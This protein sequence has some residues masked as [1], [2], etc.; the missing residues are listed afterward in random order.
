MS[1][2]QIFSALEKNGGSSVLLVSSD[3]GTPA[4]VASCHER[5]P[6]VPVIVVA[7]AAE[8]KSRQD[9]HAFAILDD[10][11]SAGDLV[12]T[13]VVAAEQGLPSPTPAAALEHSAPINRSAP[14]AFEMSSELAREMEASAAAD[15][16]E[17]DPIGAHTLAGAKALAN[18]YRLLDGDEFR[19]NGR[20]S[21]HVSLILRGAKQRPIWPATSAALVRSLGRVSL[22]MALL[23]K[24]DRALPLAPA[25]K[26]AVD[27]IASLTKSIVE[28]LP[29]SAAVMEVLEQVG[30]RFD[31]RVSAGTPSRSG[32]R[33]VAGA[34]A[35]RLAIDYDHAQA[36]G[37]SHQDVMKELGAD[38]GRYD[39]KM[40][41]AVEEI[42]TP[43]PE[44]SNVMVVKT[45]ELKVGAV[46][47]E[48]L[49]GTDGNIIF[50]EAHALS[51]RDLARIQP[52]VNE[53]RIRET[54]VIV[55]PK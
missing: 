2:E 23:D 42:E 11:T 16:S 26:V 6:H 41:A 32:D 13:V 46:F 15:D 37:L 40:L 21:R 30:L 47:A 17:K 1:G 14:Q 34:R 4:F 44:E 7:P 52:L 36:R 54:V 38:P 39:P 25:E 48:P 28:P 35:L 3:I 43:P 12:T 5:H 29:G 50:G 27:R 9:T 18:L 24:I 20:Y 8:A 33:I 55:R 19:R 31:G 10:A 51:E 49:R 53:H 22:P 45:A